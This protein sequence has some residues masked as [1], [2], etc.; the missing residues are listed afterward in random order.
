MINLRFISQGLFDFKPRDFCEGSTC[1]CEKSEQC[2]PVLATLD[3]HNDRC[4]LQKDRTLTQYDMEKIK[5]HFITRLSENNVC[6]IKNC[7][8]VF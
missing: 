6:P 2:D 1:N 7:P 4:N 5:L 3:A 8:T